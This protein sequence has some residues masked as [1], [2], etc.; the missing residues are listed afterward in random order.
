MHRRDNRCE[1][2]NE[3]FNLP[4]EKLNIKRMMKT[5]CSCCLGPIIKHILFSASLIP[6]AHVVL[7]QV[8]H[9]MENI[10]QSPHEELSLSEVLVASCALL[11]SSIVL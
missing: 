8:L 2:C 1:I 3:Q 4:D 7:Q 5:F 9:C 6:L 10:N 11:T